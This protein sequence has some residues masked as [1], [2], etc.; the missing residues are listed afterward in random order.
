MGH[1]IYFAADWRTRVC[2]KTKDETLRDIVIIFFLLNIYT[3]YFEYFWDHT[4][5][6][7][8]FA[9]LALSFWLIGK[10]AEQLRKRL[11]E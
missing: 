8:F 10:K 5:K 2:D 7:L 11:S 3:R 1:C 9:L 6:G 4:N